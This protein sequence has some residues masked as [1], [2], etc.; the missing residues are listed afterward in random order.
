MMLYVVS[1]P[2]Y[3]WAVAQQKMSKLAQTIIRWNWILLIFERM[4]DLA[5]IECP[6]FLC[7]CLFCISLQKL[8]LNILSV[9]LISAANFMQN[10]VIHPKYRWCIYSSKNHVTF[11]VK[12]RCACVKKKHCLVA[13]VGFACSRRTPGTHRDASILQ[14]PDVCCEISLLTLKSQVR[15]IILASKIIGNSYH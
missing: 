14:H 8:Y 11:T 10:F 7:I 15:E 5:K 13:N 9:K 4:T 1:K 6:F 2:A 3:L 12:E